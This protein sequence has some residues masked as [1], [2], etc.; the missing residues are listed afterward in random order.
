MESANGMMAAKAVKDLMEICKDLDIGGII[1]LADKRQEG[2]AIR[3][4]ELMQHAN[5]YEPSL[6]EVLSRMI[7]E[8]EAK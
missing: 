3:V 6:P 8:A 1:L 5:E 4:I 2:L 7:T